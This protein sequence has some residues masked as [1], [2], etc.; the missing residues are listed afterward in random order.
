MSNSERATER[1]QWNP[2]EDP[3]ACSICGHPL[4]ELKRV[5]GEEHC[6]ACQREYGGML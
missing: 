1:E 4:H 2:E 5:K 6:D 3:F